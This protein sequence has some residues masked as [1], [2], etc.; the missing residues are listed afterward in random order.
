[1][2]FLPA[3]QCGDPIYNEQDGITYPTV[4][5]NDNNCWLQSNLGTSIVATAHNDTDAYGWYYQWGRETDGH[6]FPNST[7]TSTPSS[8]DSPGHAYFITDTSEPYDW[9]SPSNSDLW[10][11][12][13]GV[14]N[15]CPANWRVPN[16]FEW[17]T[18]ISL[19]GIVNHT[20]AASSSLK[21]TTSGYRLQTGSSPFGGGQFASYWTSSS[22]GS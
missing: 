5:A 16:K 21:I 12:V 19:E 20:T 2:E 1:M 7:T 6:Q 15:P 17:E 8:Q 14:N 13:N 10:D 18:L 22:A 11:G 9:R 4:F 3:W